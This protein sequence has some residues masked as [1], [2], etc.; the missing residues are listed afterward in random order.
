MASTLAADKY[1]TCPKRTFEE[2]PMQSVAYAQLSST[3]ILKRAQKKVLPKTPLVCRCSGSITVIVFVESNKT[4]CATAKNGHPLL[5]KAAVDAAS[6]WNYRDDARLGG[7]F[8]GELT[9]SFEGNHVR[10]LN[11]R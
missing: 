1:S 7:T 3:D 11:H 6:K 4:V 8:T 9:F 2:A 10:L 5:Q